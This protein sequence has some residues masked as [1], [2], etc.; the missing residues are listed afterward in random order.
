VIRG[1][2]PSDYATLGTAWLA[3]S[4]AT[5]TLLCERDGRVAG[6]ACYSMIGEIAQLGEVVVSEHAR[7]R[8]VA[9][10][11]IAGVARLLRACGVREWQAS[12]APDHARA[13]GLYERFGLRVEHASTVVRLAWACALALPAAP[14]VALPIAPTEDDDIERALGLLGGRIAM[15]RRRA[16][17]VELV[18]LRDVRCTP[19]GYAAFDPA[20]PGVL[21]LRVDQPML[22]GTLFAALRPHAR[23]AWLQ[24]VVEDDAALV[25]QLVAAGGERTRELLHFR[26]SLPVSHGAGAGGGGG[27]GATGGSK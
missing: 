24:V 7:G 8:G 20:M 21:E 5:A 10:E 15:H 18:Q 6:Y 19:V 22:A 16:G 13:I 23:H 11:L 12:V 27:S 17:G 26:G 25:A 2:T 3:R 4:R 9:T 1:A 14:V